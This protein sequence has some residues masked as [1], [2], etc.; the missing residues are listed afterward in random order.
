MNCIGDTIARYPDVRFNLTASGGYNYSARCEICDEQFSGIIGNFNFT[1]VFIC[2]SC[3]VPKNLDLKFRFNWRANLY[4]I[5][6]YRTYNSDTDE[7]Q[8]ELGNGFGLNKD[9]KCE[10][11]EC[12]RHSTDIDAGSETSE[13]ISSNSASSSERESGSESESD[14][15]G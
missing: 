15:D 12:T 7:H 6:K 4:F 14:S 2:G 10:C 3:E 5:Y 8:W 11:H 9:S 1:F 13:Y